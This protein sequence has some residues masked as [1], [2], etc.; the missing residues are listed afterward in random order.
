MFEVFTIVKPKM[1]QGKFPAICQLKPYRKY[2]IAVDILS[3]QDGYASDIVQTEIQFLSTEK[4]PVT[5]S[6]LVAR[7]PDDD[8]GNRSDVNHIGPR[9][10]GNQ[11]KANG[12]SDLSC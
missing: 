5:D 10:N 9:C 11:A 3:L 7:F 1:D 2:R 4:A 8:S 12:Q 6:K